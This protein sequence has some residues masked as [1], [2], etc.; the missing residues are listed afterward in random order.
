MEPFPLSVRYAFGC[1]FLFW[2]A[3]NQSLWVVF[4]QCVCECG[5]FCVFSV[6]VVDLLCTGGGFL[7]G[8]LILFLSLIGV[9][10]YVYCC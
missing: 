3:E 6:H 4:V 1:K 10:H 9:I 7:F 5:L 8:V 2:D